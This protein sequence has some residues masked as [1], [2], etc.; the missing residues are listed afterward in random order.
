MVSLEFCASSA[1]VLHRVPGIES[2]YVRLTNLNDWFALRTASPDE[3]RYRDG[4]ATTKGPGHLKRFLQ[5]LIPDSL[6]HQVATH[7]IDPMSI[8][9]MAFH[10]VVSS[11]DPKGVHLFS[12]NAWFRSFR[13][14]NPTAVYAQYWGDPWFGDLNL[15]R[16]P[17]TIWLERLL[18]RRADQIVFNTKQTLRDKQQQHRGLSSRMEMISRGVD[19]EA[20]ALLPCVHVFPRA[21]SLLYAGD[22]YQ[23]NRSIAPL[24]TAAES[25]GLPLSVVGDGDWPK[26]RVSGVTWRPRVSPGELRSHIEQASMLVVILNKRGSQ[27][28]GKIYDFATEFRPVLVLYEDP[29][30]IREFPMASR[31][32]FA[33]NSVSEIYKVLT[34][35]SQIHVDFREVIAASSE[36]AVSPLFRALKLSNLTTCT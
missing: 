4:K 1:N 6:A 16:A 25:A 26:Q 30:V 18:L 29:T 21:S 10:A 35:S 8:D 36:S 13:R 20:A 34:C 2:H 14:D 22:F 19:R 7:R 32:I 12:F 31:F 27:I 5:S 33:S 15:A 17:W 28:P 24:V 3:R 9:P 23:V 11:S